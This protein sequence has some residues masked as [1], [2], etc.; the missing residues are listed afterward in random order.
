MKYLDKNGFQ[1]QDEGGKVYVIKGK[2]E[3]LWDKPRR[4]VQVFHVAP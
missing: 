2:D 3:K 4:D 1:E